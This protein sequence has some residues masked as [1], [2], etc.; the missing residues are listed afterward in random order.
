MMDEKKLIFHMSDGQRIIIHD[1][2]NVDA[3]RGMLSNPKN[4]W[5]QFDRATIM[6][7]HIVWMEE[8]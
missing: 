1:W 6:V 3:I 7:A 2:S 4:R 5:I 8:A